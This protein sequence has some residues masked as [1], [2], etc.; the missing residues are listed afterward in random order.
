MHRNHFRL[1]ILVCLIVIGRQTALSQTTSSPQTAGEP[2][3]SERSDSL[4][5][6]HIERAELA[7]NQPDIRITLNV[8]SF[9]LTLWQNGK[10]VKS[11]F[12]GVGMKAHPI[13]I[14]DREAN[15]LIWNPAWIPPSSDWVLEMKGVSPGEVIKASDPRNPLGKMKIPLGDRYLIHQAAKPTDLGNLVSHGCIRM[16]R[17][18]IYDLAEKIVA[19]R[20]A[21]VSAKRIEAA[22]HSSRTLV[23]QLDEPVPVDINYDTLVVE[24]GVLHV[25]P[26]VYDRGTNRPARLRAELLTA[27]VDGSNLSEKTLRQ[28]LSKVT[29]HTQFVVEV[30]SI[31]EGRAIEDGRVLPL[32]PKAAPRAR[33]KR[34]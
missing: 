33:G 27:N 11:Y 10:E 34:N 17:S 12:V 3:E 8:P 13:Y 22:K 20:R 7:P 25:Y 15:E 30:R 5:G 4:T 14:G 2:N 18:E 6:G 31:S 23:V 9:R 21:P 26:D 1:F 29:R 19:A 16:L 32:I 28:I 24:E